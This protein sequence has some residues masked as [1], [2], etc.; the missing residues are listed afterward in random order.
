ML[1][2][3]LEYQNVK[4]DRL[5]VTLAFL[6]RSPIGRINL[7]YLTGRRVKSGPTKVGLVII[8]FHPK[9]TPH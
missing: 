7:S 5:T 2:H 4:G 3:L 6:Y 8:R 9:K 1:N